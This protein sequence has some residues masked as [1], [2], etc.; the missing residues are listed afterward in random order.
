MNKITN[1]PRLLSDEEYDALPSSLAPL[2]TCIV[3]PWLV[4]VMTLA[5]LW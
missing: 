1:N 3:A 4:M 5:W 2:I